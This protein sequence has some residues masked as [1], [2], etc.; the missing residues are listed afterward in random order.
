MDLSEHEQIADLKV[1]VAGLDTGD[2]S[3]GAVEN[4][5][6]DIQC[7]VC[8]GAFFNGGEVADYSSRALAEQV[9]VIFPRH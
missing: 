4:E 5:K 3:K 7:P 1:D 2:A 8:H 6:R 9:G